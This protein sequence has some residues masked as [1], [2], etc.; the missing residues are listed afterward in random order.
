MMNQIRS[1]AIA[2]T[3]SFIQPASA[4]LPMLEQPWLGYFA[5]AQERNFQFLFSS[6]GGFN[7]MVLDHQGA[8]IQQSIGL[9]FLGLETLP[10]GS[11]KELPMAL[12]T[13]ESSDPP[14][15]KLKKT[16]FRFKLTDQATG[17]AIGQPTMEGTIEIIS[18][19]VLANARIIDKGASDKNPIQPV[20]RT[21]F[22]AF[23]VN[24]N[25]HKE[26]WDKKQVKEFE[27][28]IGADSVTLK[29][30]DEKRVKLVCVDKTDPKSKE[31]NGGGSSL[32]EVE[33]SFYQ[34]R[35]IELLAAPNSSLTL[36][37]AGPAPLHHGFWFQWSADAAKDPDGK[38][39]L[40]LRIQ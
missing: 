17:Q 36:C 14:T 27:K 11:I 21:I 30:L 25:I 15:A 33:I 28:R 7:L 2:A 13:F 5:V 32:A 31:V 1:M 39:K 18:G 34:K 23:Y 10:D 9:Q 29:H 3:L 40:A 22:T 4:E 35:K 12:D 24:E 6:K 16:V 37:N 19:T 8:P 20:I 26:S 38:A